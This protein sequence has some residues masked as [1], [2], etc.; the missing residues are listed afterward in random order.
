MPNPLPAPIRAAGCTRQPPELPAPLPLL[1]NLFQEVLGVD[2]LS[3]TFTD[4]SELQ[5]DVLVIGLEFERLFVEGA[6]TPAR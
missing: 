1:R 4:L 5:Q 3:L 6:Q 2:E